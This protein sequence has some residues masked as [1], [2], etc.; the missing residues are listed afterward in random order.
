VT[1]PPMSE[2][3]PAV[4]AVLKR[5]RTVLGNMALENKGKIFQRWPIDHEPLRADARNLLPDLDAV[6]TRLENYRSY[7]AAVGT[8]RGARDG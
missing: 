6:L 5:C 4:D 3:D 8:I 1:T 2:I 7:R